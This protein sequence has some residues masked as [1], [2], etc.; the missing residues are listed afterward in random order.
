[1]ALLYI[2]LII[3]AIGVLLMSQEGKGIL[4]FLILLG[5]LYLGFWI[6]MFVIAFFSSVNFEPALD[7]I[8]LIFLAVIM[9]YFL[10]NFWK[11]RRQIPG[12]IKNFFVQKWEKE[13]VGSIVGII[14]II[15]IIGCII[16]TILVGV[17]SS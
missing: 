16:W 4:N 1:M 14:G 7:V 13:R 15:A 11:I 8:G 5:L 9:V 3:I 6:V 10:I 2:L 17:W 12:N